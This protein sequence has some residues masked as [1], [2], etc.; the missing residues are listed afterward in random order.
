[1]P[2]VDGRP[3][4]A[5]SIS[6]FAAEASAAT[7]HDTDQFREV[8]AFEKAGEGPV[9]RPNLGKPRFMPS[10]VFMRDRSTR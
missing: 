7:P 2:A 6:D 4:V 3:S 9:S 10:G 8:V 5:A 1:M